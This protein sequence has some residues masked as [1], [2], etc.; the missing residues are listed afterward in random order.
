MHGGCEI[1]RGATVNAM[2]NDFP[3]GNILKGRDARLLD[4]MIH[5]NILRS[6]A[7][8]PGNRQKTDM[9]A[10]AVV[11]NLA[12]RPSL[13]NESLGRIAVNRHLGT[14]PE[15]RVAKFEIVQP[16]PE[17]ARMNLRGI[18]G[19][20]GKRKMHVVQTARIGRTG[21]HKRKSLNHFG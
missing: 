16:L 14:A 19:G 10:R 6:T 20:A 12:R 15:I 11:V 2:A 5:F 13:A 1:R 3:A 7:Q 9:L 4:W 8:M 21:F 17:N 18:V